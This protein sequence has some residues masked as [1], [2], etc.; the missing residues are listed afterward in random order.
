MYSATSALIQT[1]WFPLSVQ[2]L[3][4]HMSYSTLYY[5]ISFVLDDFAP[6][7]ANASVL[8][9]FKGE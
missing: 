7:W 2:Y 9:T 6:M 8:S 1:S 3:I 4:N 5:E